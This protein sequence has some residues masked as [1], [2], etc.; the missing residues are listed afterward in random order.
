MTPW[1]LTIDLARSWTSTT[2][3]FRTRVGS[4]ARSLP[5]SQRRVCF[6][7]TLMCGGRE[8]TRLRHLYLRV[9]TYNSLETLGLPEVISSWTP[10]TRTGILLLE[11]ELA[12]S[13]KLRIIA[14][15]RW[16]SLLAVLGG[17]GLEVEFISIRLLRES[18]ISANAIR[19]LTQVRNIS[20][21]SCRLMEGSSSSPKQMT[22]SPFAPS[23]PAWSRLLATAHGKS[24]EVTEDFERMSSSYERL[25]KLE[26]SEQGRLC[27]QKRDSSTGPS[28]ESTVLRRIRRQGF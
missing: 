18:L 7:A 2:I 17:E 16:R 4:P 13:Q 9:W 11:E 14:L 28:Q 8:R 5:T 26:R 23:A 20:P 12:L 21:N 19:R 10:S 15:P 27:K 6:P 24:R 3:I 25:Q 1:R 22:S